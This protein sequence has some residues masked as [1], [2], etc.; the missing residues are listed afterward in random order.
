MVGGLLM[1]AYN[2]LMNE[3][4]LDNLFGNNFK[5]LKDTFYIGTGL[6]AA[7]LIYLQSIGRIGLRI[8]STIIQY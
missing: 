6:T 8:P 2:G 3:N 1:L 4:L 7:Y 5:L